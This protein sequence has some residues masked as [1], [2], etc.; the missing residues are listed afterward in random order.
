MGESHWVGSRSLF[1][2]LLM[3]TTM[4][5][6]INNFLLTFMLCFLGISM[7]AGVAYWLYGIIS[8]IF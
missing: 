5:N 2:N 8:L 1:I 6:K 7:V 4:W 3:H